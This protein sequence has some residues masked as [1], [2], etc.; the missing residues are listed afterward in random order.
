MPGLK[1]DEIEMNDIDLFSKKNKSKNDSYNKK[2]ENIIAAIINNNI[3]KEY[4]SGSHKWR[5]LKKELYLYIQ[6]LGK[7]MALKLLTL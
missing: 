1:C 3:P 7:R 2:R 5:D 4:Y 6:I